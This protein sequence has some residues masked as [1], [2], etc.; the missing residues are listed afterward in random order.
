MAHKRL[1]LKMARVDNILFG[2]VAHQDEKLRWNMGVLAEDG[3]FQ[4]KSDICPLLCDGKR[5]YVRGRTLA[6]DC[7]PFAH[8]YNTESGAKIAMAA[9]KA[10]VSEINAEPEQA[11]TEHPQP[12]METIQ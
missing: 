1:V 5:L 10:L 11:D 6:N 7:R 8:A 9:F 12:E 3:E 4:I 2:W